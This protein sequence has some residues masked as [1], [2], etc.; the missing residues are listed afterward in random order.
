M[1]TK[2][3]PPA[4][5]WDHRNRLTRRMTASFDSAD[6]LD[7]KQVSQS[8]QM[9]QEANKKIFPRTFKPTMSFSKQHFWMPN[10]RF[11]MEIVEK[12]Q[13]LTTHRR[14]RS[15]KSFETSYD[16]AKHFIG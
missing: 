16:H 12:H 14:L 2:K 10:M 13:K 4:H 15:P 7:P 6:T 9:H 11:F 8:H 3:S 1:K 5:V